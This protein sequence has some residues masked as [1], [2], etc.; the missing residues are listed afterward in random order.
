VNRYR[1]ESNILNNG[2]QRDTLQARS[3]DLTTSHLSKLIELRKA[4]A[5]K[6]I[7]LACSAMNRLQTVSNLKNARD[8]S[9]L[10]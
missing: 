4:W 8:L 9:K 10:E 3:T 2:M 6:T 5:L 7:A 1:N